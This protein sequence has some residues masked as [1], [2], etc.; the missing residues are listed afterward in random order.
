MAGCS[1]SSPNAWKRAQPSKRHP[2]RR[3]ASCWAWLTLAWTCIPALARADAQCD[4]WPQWQRFKQLYLSTD[5]RVVDAS[6][7]RKITVSEGQSYA[8]MFA[9]I[10]ND[11]ASFAR[12]LQWTQ[13]NLSGGD[14]SH[15]L[16]AWQW[17]Q[18]DGGAWGVLDENSASDADLWIAYSLMQAGTLWH[19]ER[20]SALGRAV[21]T[22]VLRDEVALI[23]GLGPMLLPGPKG[24]VEHDTWRLN[25]SYV[26]IQVLRAFGHQMHDKLWDE[27]LLSSQRVIIASAPHGAAADWLDYRT[28]GTFVADAATQGVGSYDAIRVYLWAGTLSGADP[29]YKAL[30]HQFAPLLALLA[31]RPD[32]PE[33]IEP[34]N[35]GTRG[36]GHHGFY[37][38]LLP[39]LSHADAQQLRRYRARIDTDALRDDQHYYNDV[40]TLFGIGFADGRYH[41][42]R[43]G[44]LRPQWSQ[45]CIAP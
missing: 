43:D 32:V 38:A 39:L 11:P 7:P 25:P 3:L 8:L 44:G 24:F 15:K 12:V 28:D 4:L 2:V 34:A 36:E 23:P 30:A 27:V 21:A 40:L 29:V 26:P 10:A 22:R 19:N 42:E 45:P 31:L 41:F 14:L 6:N 33:V 18:T 35:L 17:G 37:A 13:N 16:P 9:L 5:G 1:G 20:Y